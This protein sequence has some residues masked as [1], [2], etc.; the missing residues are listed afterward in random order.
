MKVTSAQANK[1]LRQLSDELS[2]LETREQNTRSFVAATSEDIESVRP[3]YDYSDTQEKIIALE[4]KI[5][6]LKHAIN[7][8]NTITV[9]PDFNMTIDMMLVYLPQLTR[10]KSKLDRMKNMLPKER[11]S[12]SSRGTQLIE[13]RYA[14]FDI[15]QVKADY[16]VVSDLLSRA[17][18]ALDYANNTVEFD[19]EI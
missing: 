2:T 19:L 17:Q 3:E 1:L 18:T 13:Y 12:H 10:R 15:E 14:N 11:E 16:A 9:I 7:T 5:R 6:A 4:T 8:F